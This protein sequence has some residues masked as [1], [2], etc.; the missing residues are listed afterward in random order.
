M[1]ARETMLEGLRKVTNG[2]VRPREDTSNDESLDSTDFL[3]LA[4][5]PVPDKLSS[6]EEGSSEEEVEE[7]SEEGGEEGIE[8]LKENV[9]LGHR[10]VARV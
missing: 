8:D 9:P 1:G 4:K 6:E 2:S 3:D 7:G 5:F 10:K